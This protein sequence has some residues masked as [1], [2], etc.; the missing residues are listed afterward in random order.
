[1]ASA[2]YCTGPKS[3][4]GRLRFQDEVGRTMGCSLATADYLAQLSDPTYP[5]KLGE[6]YAEFSESDDF[7]NVPQA[8][9]AFKSE[10]DLVRRTPGFWTHFVKPK[11]EGDFQGVYRFL[12]RPLNSGRNDYLDAI[13]ENFAI[14]NR[15]IAASGAASS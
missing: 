11:L 12:E 2:I 8:A 15:R 13:E 10:E 14:I 4:I 3:E 5:D 6:L 9:R 7:A 1:V